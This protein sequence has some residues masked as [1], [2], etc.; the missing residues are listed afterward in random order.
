M[1]KNI[2][3]E[4]VAFSG[5]F[6]IIHVD[7][8]NPPQALNPIFSGSLTTASKKRADGNPGVIWEGLVASRSKPGPYESLRSKFHTGP[9]SNY[10]RKISNRALGHQ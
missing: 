3:T 8:E 2:C 5:F 9:K 6:L 1:H 7:P 4:F 10:H